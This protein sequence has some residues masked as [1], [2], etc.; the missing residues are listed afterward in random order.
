VKEMEQ[1]YSANDLEQLA[2]LEKAM[3]DDTIYKQKEIKYSVDEVLDTIKYV[4]T[5]FEETYGRPAGNYFT[6]GHCYY[7]AKML[8]TLF[9]GNTEIM[10]SDGHYVAKIENLNYDVYG[11]ISEPAE[12]RYLIT[13]EE[14]PIID[15]IPTSKYEQEKDEQ[16]ITGLIT[17]VENGKAILEKEESKKIA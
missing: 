16:I 1:K 10:A 2:A 4:N 15:T 14:G 5:I 8:K 12:Y 11:V 17:A 6:T 13:D 3:N 7:Y 9:P